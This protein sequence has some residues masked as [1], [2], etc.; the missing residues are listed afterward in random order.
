[1]TLVGVSGLLMLSCVFALLL[2]AR[3]AARVAAAEAMRIS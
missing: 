1:V 2:P 3:R